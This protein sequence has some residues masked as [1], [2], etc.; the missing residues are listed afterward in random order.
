M[1]FCDRFTNKNPNREGNN[2]FCREILNRF[3]EPK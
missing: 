3:G 2:L 1:C